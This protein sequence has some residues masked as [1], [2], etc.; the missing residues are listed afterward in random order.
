MTVTYRSASSAAT[1]APLYIY[2]WASLEY[3]RM[4]PPTHSGAEDSVRLLLTRNLAHSFSCPWCQ[5]HGISFERFPRPWQTVGPVSSPSYCADSSLDFFKE[6]RPLPE[7]S[8]LWFACTVTSLAQTRP[9]SK[10]PPPIAHGISPRVPLC[11]ESLFG[12]VQHEWLY[13]ITPKII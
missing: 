1:D 13:R 7:L 10:P 3:H 2:F 9:R 5:I 4:T 8:R 6:V 12:P 11:L